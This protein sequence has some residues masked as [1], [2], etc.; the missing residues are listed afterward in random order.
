MHEGGG[1]VGGRPSIDFIHSGIHHRFGFVLPIVIRAELQRHLADA[2]RSPP[3]PLMANGNWHYGDVAMRDTDIIATVDG[4]H[5]ALHKRANPPACPHRI[6]PHKGTSYV[7]IYTWCTYVCVCVCVCVCMWVCAGDG[8]GV[9][10]TY[11]PFSRPSNV[12]AE[13]YV[14]SRAALSR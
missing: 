2:K 13:L 8:T 3:S 9:D 7:A 4:S 5:R 1:Q 11:R 6:C 12:N 10:V 14:K